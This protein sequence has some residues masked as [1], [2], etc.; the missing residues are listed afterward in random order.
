MPKENNN[1][2]VDIENLFKQNVNDL[3]A[4]KEL[5]RKLEELGEKITQIKYIDNTLVKKLKKEYEKLQKIILDENIQVKLTDDIEKII[6]QM[7]TNVQKIISP[8]MFG[9]VGDG[10]TNDFEAIKKCFSYSNVIINFGK[11][12]IYSIDSVGIECLGNNIILN[13]N[14]STIK[15]SDKNIVLNTIYK[16]VSSEKDRTIVMFYGDNVEINNIYFDANNDNNFILYNDKK[17]YGLQK[18]IVSDLPNSPK[19]LTIDAIIARG[20][21]Y[22][23]T[24]CNFKGF[25]NAIQCGGVWGSNVKKY[26]YEIKNCEFLNGFRDQITA[27]DGENLNIIDCTFRDNQR[28]A[29]QFYRNFNNGVVSNCDI[30]NTIE[31]IRLW[32]PTWSSSNSDAELMGIGISNPGYDDCCN[33][34]KI[35]NCNINVPKIG[36]SARNFSKNITIENNHIKSNDICI[37]LHKGLLNNFTVKNNYL[38]GAYGVNLYLGNMTTK[39][40]SENLT[41]NIEKNT[42]KVSIQVYRFLHDDISSKVLNACYIYIKNNKYLSKT[43]YYLQAIKESSKLLPIYV[44]VYDYDNIL[45]FNNHYYLKVENRSENKKVY[46]ITTGSRKSTNGC[47]YKIATFEFSELLTRVTLK[48]EISKSSGDS[49]AFTNFF[50]SLRTHYSTITG[51]PSFQVMTYN[52]IITSN[53]YRVHTNITYVDDKMICELY[54]SV[55]TEITGG[56]TVK[57][58]IINTNLDDKINYSFNLN[59]KTWLNELTGTYTFN[60]TDV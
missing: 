6:S 12:K 16:S 58:E 51:K 5:Y 50:V 55:P 21:N 47:Y 28:K 40:D 23:I 46:E 27:C 43:E 11:S 52:N 13:G 24:N 33:Y 41:I 53:K 19:Y 49:F 38:E 54:F 8:E 32:Y 18:D 39:Y 37:I 30:K 2:Q 7:D 35:E 25:G 31:N 14:G 45:N 36:I 1:M 59:D 26:N 56:H 48:G 22:K 20:N 57:T 3:S 17:Y 60:S 29:I 42:F 10:I 4:I 9:A 44:F 34:I 15:I